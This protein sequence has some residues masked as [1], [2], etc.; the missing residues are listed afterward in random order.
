MILTL[1]RG[2]SAPNSTP[3]QLF[4]NGV[5]ECFTLED[6]V[7]PVKIK[8]KTAIPKGT[9]QVIVDF[10]N[11]FQKLMPLLV[12]VPNYEGIRIHPG[13]TAEDTDGCILVGTKSVKTNGEYTIQNSRIA[14]DAL[15]AK[16]VAANKKEKITISIED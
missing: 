15:F 5:F 6:V 3:G 8:G 4:I 12:N 11:R 2:A 14:Y 7:R 16:L 1:K 9:Y 13:N 10:S